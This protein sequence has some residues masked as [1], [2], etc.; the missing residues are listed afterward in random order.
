MAEP[1]APMQQNG[2]ALQGGLLAPIRIKGRGQP[3]EREPYSRSSAV[4]THRSRDSAARAET[5]CGMVKSVRAERMGRKEVTKLLEQIRDLPVPE[6]PRMRR[7]ETLD[8]LL[9]EI[10]KAL[11][12][13]YDVEQIAKMLSDGGF[14]IE[15]ETLGRHLRGHRYK[16]AKG[17]GAQQTAS[18]ETP[19]IPHSP[20]RRTKRASTEKATTA[21]K[22]RPKGR[23]AAA[24]SPKNGA[25]QT[26]GGTADHTESAELQPSPDEKAGRGD[27]PQKS[28]QDE[29]WTDADTIAGVEAAR[30]CTDPAIPVDLDGQT[31]EACNTAA[32]AALPE[33]QSSDTTSLDIS[34]E[35]GGTKLDIHRTPELRAVEQPRD[36]QPD[37]NQEGD[38]SPLGPKAADSLGLGKT[39]TPDGKEVAIQE[40]YANHTAGLGV[41]AKRRRGGFDP[42]PARDL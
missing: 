2:T 5:E 32:V 16:I 17:V 1:T 26:E 12:R 4:E 6:N 30:D 21:L 22:S 13:G 3:T 41:V 38:T 24:Y 10:D 20:T 11:G 27:G 14:R 7:R 28:A 8:A 39:Q 23:T 31:A 9:P 34:I 19:R 18:A 42:P 15:T 25:R 35:T 40:P 37:G 29:H 36:A 33:G